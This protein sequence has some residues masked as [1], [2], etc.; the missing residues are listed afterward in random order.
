MKNGIMMQYFEWDIPA[1]GS[2][3]R[4]LKEEA[5]RL[6]QAGVTAVWMPPACKGF[7]GGRDSGYGVYDLY[8][9][10]EF[11]KQ[12]TE[13]YRDTDI[14][15][16]YG[17][18]EEYIEAI[19]ACKEAGIQA[20]A[21][22]VINHM[23]GA[24]RTEKVR[25]V[26]WRRNSEKELWYCTNEWVEIDAWTDFQHAGRNKKY[27][28][29]VW[30]KDCFD[31][32]DT[33]G[34]TY[35]PNVIYLFEGKEWDPETNF[36]FLN[37]S[38]VDAQSEE[39]LEELK[40]WGKWYLETTGIDGVRLDALKHI[41]PAMYNEWLDFMCGVQPLFVVGEYYDLACSELERYLGHITSE[42]VQMHLFDFAL[43]EKF[44][45][46]SEQMGY[47]LRNL[48]EEDTLMRNR[49]MNAVTFVDNHDTQVRL[50]PYSKVEDREVK[51]W[52]KPQ[53][54]AFILLRKQGYP[55]VFYKDYHGEET[56]PGTNAHKIRLLMKI[57]EAY[58]Y[59]TQ[60]DYIAAGNQIGWTREAIGKRSGVAVV[61][62]KDDCE[63]MRMQV[64]SGEAGKTYVNV[65]APENEVVIRED[66][67]ADFVVALGEVS[68]Y[69][70]KSAYLKITY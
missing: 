10:G 56:T 34:T 7:E 44:Y 52:F 59:G 68:V 6:R 40:R 4:T 63:P 69:V 8:D 18:K 55:C 50:D 31:G 11:Y 1:D 19:K 51:A 62:S 57:R 14:R 46:A 13:E 12:E 5:G 27:S 70:E 16:K 54:Y 21:D 41:S 17:T 67:M 49:P 9:L 30:N 37:C 64:G 45:L 66:G 65:F 23:T 29:F 32:V 20:Y 24:G 2:L 47:P 35:D 36:D 28:S 48:L 22:I 61:M 60:H 3:W 43:H 25:A 58:A 53:A 15:T 42:K 33:D 39:V 26:K 38:D